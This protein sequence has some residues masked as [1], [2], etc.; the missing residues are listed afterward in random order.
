MTKKLN[1][2][3]THF[4]FRKINPFLGKF[5]IDL[6]VRKTEETNVRPSMVK[7]GFLRAN[8]CLFFALKKTTNG[9]VDK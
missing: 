7:K 9:V 6:F 1:S 8:Q 2:G 3:G 4:L 5:S